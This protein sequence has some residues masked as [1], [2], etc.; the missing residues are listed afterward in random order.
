MYEK[1]K[2][3]LCFAVWYQYI[4]FIKCLYISFCWF[5]FVFQLVVCVTH[6]MRRIFIR[7]NTEWIL[8]TL[9]IRH[10]HDK[11]VWLYERATISIPIYF[12]SYIC[13]VGT[14]TIYINNKRKQGRNKQ[15]PKATTK[16]K[17]KRRT[18][19]FHGVCI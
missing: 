6:T 10:E 4:D 17:A 12:L 14:R 3:F 13:V 15:N 8:I 1:A 19:I 7:G 2:Y 16:N 5:V 18:Y 11:Y 9:L